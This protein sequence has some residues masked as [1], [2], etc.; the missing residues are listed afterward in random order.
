MRSSRADL[1][2]RRGSTAAVLALAAALVAGAMFDADARQFR[3]RR[4]IATPEAA[5]ARLPDGAQP[6]SPIVPLTR[7]HVRPALERL[8]DAWNSGRLARHLDPAFYDRSRLAD[9]LDTLA[10]RDARLYLQGIEGVQTLQQY[11]EADPERPNARRLVSR[12]SVTARTQ[13]E[14][15]SGAGFVRR[16]GINEFLL[17]IEHQ[18]VRR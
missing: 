10:P 12:V 14:F 9:A 7:E 15:E 13:I 17:R 1:G 8:I 2:R 11:I 3:G 18:E 6:V 16:S 5:S 4:P